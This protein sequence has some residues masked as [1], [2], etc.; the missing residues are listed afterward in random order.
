MTKNSNANSVS[1]YFHEIKVYPRLSKELER[2]IADNKER[3]FTELQDKVLSYP[4]SWE[5]IFAMWKYVK[6]N[7]KSCS[8]LT[9]DHG[10]FRFK[11]AELASELEK[12]LSKASEE[13]LFGDDSKVPELIKRAR[14]SKSI[15]LDVANKLVSDYPDIQNYLNSFYHYRDELIKANFK[16]V[17]NYAK[18]FSIHGVPFED[19]LQEGNLGLIRA[20][21]KFDP[22]KGHKFSTYAT[23]W[24]RQSF[25]HLVKTQSKTIRLPSHI[26]NS[27]TKLKKINEDFEFTNNRDA[28][29]AELAGLTGLSERVIEQLYESRVDPVPLEMY[30]NDFS[31]N[32]GQKVQQ[33]KEFIEDSVDYEEKIFES[34]NK[35]KL[36][37]IMDQVLEPEEKAVLLLRFGI[38][39]PELTFCAISARLDLSKQT[40]KYLYTRGLLK[41]KNKVKELL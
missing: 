21:E 18:S 6:D 33:V 27:L 14:L 10:N 32:S 30:V 2:E 22:S 11:A 19:L 7:N 1:K 13:S 3:C 12:N 5:L 41:L 36:L 25:I 8:K 20:S 40:I 28:T 23:W 17:I 31:G 26:H 38:H 15:Y 4:K 9:E 29:L 16:L 39:E 35:E 37:S 24:I 34:I